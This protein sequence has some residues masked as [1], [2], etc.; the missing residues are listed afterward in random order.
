M[1]IIKNVPIC[2]L[3][4]YTSP[5]SIGEL[6]MI[7]NVALLIMPK[8]APPEVMAALTRVEK[9]NVAVTV[10]LSTAQQLHMM[11][12]NFELTD[13]NFSKDGSSVV[14]ANGNMVISHLSPETKG[15][16]IANGVLLI[17]ENL[18]DKLGI[19]LL[20]VNG[21]TFY[22][23]FSE[24]K[25]YG[26]RLEAD[27]EFFTYL[28]PKTVVMVGNTLLLKEDVT[29]EVLEQSQAFLVSGNSIY[30]PDSLIS[31]LRA[32]AQAGREVRSLSEYK[33]DREMGADDYEWN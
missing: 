10:H 17:Q 31:Y 22:R 23:D 9:K 19:E 18:R 11:N 7:K 6:E 33:K 16:L 13:A 32:T 24:C 12:G 25:V 8:D 20:T 1:S 4:A 29:K 2:D 5:E 30:C 15:G 27:H 28:K 21:Q 3:R 14:M 26:N